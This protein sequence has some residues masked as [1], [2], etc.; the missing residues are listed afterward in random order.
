MNSKVEVLGKR[1]CLQS[2]RNLA[3]L[4][5]KASVIF[6][7]HSPASLREKIMVKFTKHRGRDWTLSSTCTAKLI[8]FAEYNL[9]PR[10]SNFAIHKLLNDLSTYVQSPGHVARNRS[11]SSTS[12]HHMCRDQILHPL[13]RQNS[14]RQ[15]PG[16]VREGDVEPSI[17]LI[18]KYLYFD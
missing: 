5:I 4:E 12:L 2:L 13:E 8:R 10:T 7:M 1:S 3:V 17:W 14:R 18:H 11:H 9:L 16:Y 15:M 6:P